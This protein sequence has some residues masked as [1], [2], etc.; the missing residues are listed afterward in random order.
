MK[1]KKMLF[2]ALIPILGLSLFGATYASAHGMFGFG[3]FGSNLTPDQIAT[4]H[5]TMFQNEADLLGIS[6]DEVKTAWSQG[7]SL[8]QLATDKGITAAQLQQKM[9]DQQLNNLKTQLQTLVDKGIITQ[10]QSDA[11]LQ[12]MQTQINNS[13]GRMFKSHGGFNISGNK[14]AK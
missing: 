12:F 7:K 8:Q 13:K 4:N 9:K 14:T 1:N 10:A 2:Y 5:Q 11:R 3:G 6:V